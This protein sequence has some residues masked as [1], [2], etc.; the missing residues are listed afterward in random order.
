MLAIVKAA[1]LNRIHRLCR[2]EAATTSV[3]VDVIAAKLINST[4]MIDL[5]VSG[6]EL[7]G[8]ERGLIIELAFV[9]AASW[10]SSSGKNA[11]PK[12]QQ[13]ADQS[14]ARAG[15]SRAPIGQ[16][17]SLGRHLCRRFH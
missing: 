11:P 6:I 1:A 14:P 10:P 17:G 12:G 3:A 16:H 4:G 2:R 5:H 7:L 9:A 8:I 13:V 15:L